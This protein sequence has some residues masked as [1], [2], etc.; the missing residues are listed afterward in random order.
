MLAYAKSWSQADCVISC[1]LGPVGSRDGLGLCNLQCG[2][3][4]AKPL[5]W[6]SST[7]IFKQMFIFNK[8]YMERLFCLV[9]F[10]LVHILIPTDTL[11]TGLKLG[12][13]IYV[14]MSNWVKICVCGCHKSVISTFNH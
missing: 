4:T 1:E 6:K 12:K 13:L 5:W 8:K 14:I 2:S 10:I 9:S 7:S 11:G 3:R